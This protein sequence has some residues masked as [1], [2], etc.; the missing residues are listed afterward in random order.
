MD[1]AGAGAGAGDDGGDDGGDD[2]G[3]DGDDG[4]DDSDDDGD[5]GDERCDDGVEAGGEAEARRRP[6]DDPRPAASMAALVA[7][8]EAAASASG[9][10]S[11]E[12]ARGRALAVAAL[13]ATEDASGPH[14]GA[15]G[16]GPLA[17]VVSLSGGLRVARDGSTHLIAIGDGLQGGASRSLPK[18]YRG[19]DSESCVRALGTAGVPLVLTHG[20]ADVTVDPR[21]S[22][23]IYDTAPGPKAIAWLD[24]ADHHCRARFDE[25]LQL[26]QRWV[27]ALVR[28]HA[29]SSCESVEAMQG[30]GTGTGVHP[31]QAAPSALAPLQGGDLAAELTALTTMPSPRT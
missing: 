12:S 5:D 4:D 13:A 9:T 21:A 7:R 27:P 23:A 20:L 29:L 22:E 30:T 19:C 14:P 15:G 28:R 26:L 16:L 18:D 8:M 2:D 17:G 1:A 6:S 10:P 11:D 25:L 24:G 31:K 3:D